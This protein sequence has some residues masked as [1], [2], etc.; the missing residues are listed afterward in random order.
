M[1]S[2]EAYF[3]LEESEKTQNC[4]IWGAAAS[5]S[6]IHE[7]S[8]HYDYVT[9]WCGMYSIYCKL[10]FHHFSALSFLT[11]FLSKEVNPLDHKMCFLMSSLYCEVLSASFLP[12]E[13]TDFLQYGTAPLLADK[14]T[15]SC[16][17]WR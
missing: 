8:L 13:N 16:S 9:V 6:V 5:L 7:L 1:R 14:R 11:F 12:L 15:A 17:L 3:N 2:D 10:L 4:F